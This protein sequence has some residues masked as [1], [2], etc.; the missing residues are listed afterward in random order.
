MGGTKVKRRLKLPPLGVG[1]P[2]LETGHEARDFKFC[3]RLKPS[4]R[5]KMQELADH[6][7]TTVTNVLVHLVDQAWAALQEKDGV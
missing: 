4:E 3:I 2:A 7:Q 6:F 1:V 5:R